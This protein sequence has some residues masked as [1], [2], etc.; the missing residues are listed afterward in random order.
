MMMIILLFLKCFCNAVTLFYAMQ[1]ELIV[2]VV[3]AQQSFLDF[4]VIV[5]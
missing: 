2:V 3:S 1:I 4:D 5:M